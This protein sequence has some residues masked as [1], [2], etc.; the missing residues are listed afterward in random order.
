MFENIMDVKNFNLVE[1]MIS[2][3]YPLD[4]PN[5]NESELNQELKFEW[6]DLQNLLNQ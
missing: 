6:L 2:K 1:D 5:I 3:D 4:I